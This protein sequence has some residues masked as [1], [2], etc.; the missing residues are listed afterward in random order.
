MNVL[1][2]VISTAEPFE[3]KTEEILQTFLEKN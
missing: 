2:Y 1:F 3:T